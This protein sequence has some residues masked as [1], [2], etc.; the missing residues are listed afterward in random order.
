MKCDSTLGRMA[1]YNSEIF[2]IFSLVFF[3][4]IVTNSYLYYLNNIII[5]QQLLEKYRLL[6]IV[7]CVTYFTDLFNI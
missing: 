7:P 6:F 2:L 5:F 1:L 3:F 4:P